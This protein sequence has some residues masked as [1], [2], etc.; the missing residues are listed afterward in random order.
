M[1]KAHSRLHA[2]VCLFVLGQ[3]LRAALSLKENDL[4]NRLAQIIQEKRIKEQKDPT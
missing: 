1:G 2:E 3:V 4:D